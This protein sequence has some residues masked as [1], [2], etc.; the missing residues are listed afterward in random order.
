M[1]HHL[2]HSLGDA[3]PF[4]TEVL[5]SVGDYRRF[6]GVQGETAAQARESDIFFG[7][8]PISDAP[9]FIPDNS[10]QQPG[11]GA[12]LKTQQLARVPKY[13]AKHS[14]FFTKSSP[15]ALLRHLSAIFQSMEG[16]DHLLI[17]AK[18]K[19]AGFAN[20]IVSR[21]GFKVSLFREHEAR[22]LC[23]FQRRSGCV[24]FFNKLWRQALDRLGVHSPTLPQGESLSDASTL[25][26]VVPFD[27]SDLNVPIS[28]DT[29]SET[30][31]WKKNGVWSLL[32]AALEPY[33]VFPDCDLCS[34]V[35]GSPCNASVAD[36]LICMAGSDF[37]DV[38]RE[39]CAGLASVSLTTSLFPVLLR[40]VPVLDNLL[41]GNDTELTRSIS[42][43]L[44]H[45]CTHEDCC[46]E[47]ISRLLPRML[48]ILEEPAHLANQDGKRHIARALLQCSHSDRCKDAIWQKVEILANLRGSQDRA[49][50]ATIVETLKELGWSAQRTPTV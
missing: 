1:E 37:V 35:P 8:K 44:D 36:T 41:A 42:V 20:G 31:M 23:E 25:D 39:G 38:Q 45:I 5:R 21:C 16:V 47:I 22:L 10:V 4:S 13:F 49:L 3:S 2:S 48:G 33:L 12:F 32:R 14:S 28:T 18:A 9:A 24:I 34:E 43:C 15:E 30:S 7:N 27:I 46:G 40:L 11:Y 17:P 50:Q 26:P 6:S 19:I 29:G